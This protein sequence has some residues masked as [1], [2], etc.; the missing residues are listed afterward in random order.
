MSGGAVRHKPGTLVRPGRR[1]SK[2]PMKSD[3]TE[4]I[5]AFLTL[6]GIPLSYSIADGL[7]LGFISY[8]L[9]KV[10][11][12][13]AREAGWLTCVLAIVLVLYFA[14]VRSRLG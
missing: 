6:I 1:D 10:L 9:L 13:R 14:L 3:R 4:S 5:P 12:G 8:P 11:T 2:T 7:A